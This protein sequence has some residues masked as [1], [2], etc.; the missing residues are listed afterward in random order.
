MDGLKKGD[1]VITDGGLMGQVWEVHEDHLILDFGDRTRIPF[2][3]SSVK[4]LQ[5]PPKEG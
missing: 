3:K 5:T 2:I 1:K 4:A